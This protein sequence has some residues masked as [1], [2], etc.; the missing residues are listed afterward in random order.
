MH[1]CRM[2]IT[3][4]IKNASYGVYLDVTNSL[5][6]RA[7]DG[8]TVILDTNLGSPMLLAKHKL[9]AH[10]RVSF[11]TGGFILLQRFMFRRCHKVV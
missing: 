4:V 7:V 9:D 2:S 11:V 6:I 5:V 10:S 1:C 8:S 3:D